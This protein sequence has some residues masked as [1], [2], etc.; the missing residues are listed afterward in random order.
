MNYNAN[1]DS[2]L[3]KLSMLL[4]KNSKDTSFENQDKILASEENVISLMT[5]LLTDKKTKVEVLNICEEIFT[6]DLSKSSKDKQRFFDYMKYDIPKILFNTLKKELNALDVENFSLT[7]NTI[8]NIVKS[9]EVKY[10]P[11]AGDYYTKSL[12]EC[13]TQH[14]KLSDNEVSQQLKNKLVDVL[15]FIAPQ[16]RRVSVS[17]FT[18][19]CLISKN[20]HPQLMKF[21]RDSSSN[22]DYECLKGLHEFMQSDDKNHLNILHLLSDLPVERFNSNASKKIYSVLAE[23]LEKKPTLK[24]KILDIV[25]RLY[26]VRHKYD[27]SAQIKANSLLYTIANKYPETIDC[28]EQFTHKKISQLAPRRDTL[29]NLEYVFIGKEK[30]CHEKFKTLYDGDFPSK[31][32]GG[33][34]ASPQAEN[35]HSEWYNYCMKN[36]PN[37][38]SKTN[39]YHIVPKKD[40]RCLV[41][42]SLNDFSPY[43]YQE[44]SGCLKFDSKALCE[45]YDCIYVPKI[46]IFGNNKIFWGAPSLVVLKADKF[47]A[48]TE[49]EWQLHKRLKKKI[50]D[51]NENCSETKSATN[52]PR[53][54]VIHGTDGRDGR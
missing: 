18:R 17:D 16:S 44:K 43:L 37:L 20:L 48:Y 50:N 35:G 42:Q 54:S 23:M 45:D 31:F 36:A 51:T 39:C 52:N 47:D 22:I 14:S 27:N 26:A 24:L 8:N 13:I 33:L 1:A 29:P 46:E 32:S 53:S 49:D 34:W 10:E 7:L 25:C 2:I 15:V 21:W 41:A 40:C 28:I 6:A 5:K 38:L 4:N 3:K 30:P 9:D 19:E 12:I 11:L